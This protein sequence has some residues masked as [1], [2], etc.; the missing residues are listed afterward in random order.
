MPGAGFVSE[1]PTT[2]S[3]DPA[4]ISRVRCGKPEGAHD[5]HL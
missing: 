2:R 1:G 3:I 5:H 4:W